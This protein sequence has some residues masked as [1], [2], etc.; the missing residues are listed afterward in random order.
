MYFTNSEKQDMYDT[1]VLCDKNTNAAARLYQE[2]YPNRRQP[3]RQLFFK[4]NNSLQHYGAFTKP[5]REVPKPVVGNE[6]NRVNI[7]AYL[8]W[9][10]QA[11]TREI[12]RECNV[13]LGSVKRILKSEK[14]HPYRFSVGH[15]LHAGDSI[16]RMQFCQFVL[17]QIQMNEDFPR[18]ILWTDECTFTNNGIFNRHNE[19]TWARRNPFLRRNIHHQIRYTINVWCGILNTNIIGPYFIDGALNGEKYRHFLEFELSSLLDD[20]PLRDRLNCKYFQQ[21]GAPAHNSQVAMRFLKNKFCNNVIATN[22]SIRWPARSPDLSP[23]D[24]FLW[25]Y[26]KDRIYSNPIDS[27]ENLRERIILECAAITA[28]NLNAVMQTIKKRYQKCLECN[29]EAFEHLLQ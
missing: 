10:P 2:K 20:I 28:D 19:H 5:K 8:Q 1:F 25:G 24:F 11:S 14:L 17:N 18:Q 29:G 22:T 7:L 15:A 9:K 16:R 3:S 27:V 12:S 23:L 26:L 13:S 4:L 21:D 6:N